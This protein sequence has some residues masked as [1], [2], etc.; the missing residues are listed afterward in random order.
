M[1]WVPLIAR[2]IDTSRLLRPRDV[3]L[4]IPHARCRSKLDVHC[5][6]ARS[7]DS[8]NQD[9]NYPCLIGRL[10]VTLFFICFVAL[11]CVA[12]TSSAH[13]DPHLYSLSAIYFSLC[14]HDSSPLFSLC[15]VHVMSCVSPYLFHIN[16][17]I[18]VKY[19]QCVK[20]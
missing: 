12:R 18:C 14:Y 19:I 1:S 9:F 6:R 5:L 8:L 2:D 7:M 15:H 20:I 16:M 4:F 11:F 3:D 10:F 13:M 17:D